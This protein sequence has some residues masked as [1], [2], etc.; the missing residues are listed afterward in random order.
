[1]PAITRDQ[2]VA[3]PVDESEET[4]GVSD[5]APRSQARAEEPPLVRAGIRDLGKTLTDKTANT[6]RDRIYRAVHQG[7][8][9]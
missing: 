7:T 2:S 8:E 9:H 6:L 1:M 4:L 3:V 5:P